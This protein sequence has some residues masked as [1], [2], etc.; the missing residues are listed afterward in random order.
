[1]E[2]TSTSLFSLGSVFFSEEDVAK[3]NKIKTEINNAANAIKSLYKMTE[4]AGFSGEAAIAQT[5]IES[6]LYGSNMHS[7]LEKEVG[8]FVL[9]NRMVN[10]ADNFFKLHKH[11]TDNQYTGITQDKM[12]KGFSSTNYFS[13]FE[14]ELPTHFLD[15]ILTNSKEEL[16]QL[17]VTRKAI[18]IKHQSLA[19][20]ILIDHSTH[21]Q[22][23][24]SMSIV[25]LMNYNTDADL[26]AQHVS[27]SF[28]QLSAQYVPEKS[29]LP[30][31]MLAKVSFCTNK[32]NSL[33]Y[34]DAVNS[35]I[36]YL[37][38]STKNLCKV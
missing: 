20:V 38:T 12:L 3:H 10:H 29:E 22:K 24:I 13:A 9:G 33:F 18:Y 4:C 6:G 32:A 2:H 21:N 8:Q 27:D 7:L 35:V 34:S 25:R 17:A 1:M 37:N 5:L 19:Y 15:A 23:P 36:E 16:K 11:L 28:E 30:V 31:A 26:L 14:F